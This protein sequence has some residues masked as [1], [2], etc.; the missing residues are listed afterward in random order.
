MIYTLAAVINANIPKVEANAATLGDALSWI[1]GAIGVLAVIF[2]IVG[3]LRYAASGGEAAAVKQAKNTITYAILG[4]VFV[5]LAYAITQFVVKSVDGSSWENLRDSVVNTLI[6]AVG[7]I[8]TIMIVVSGIRYMTSAGDAAKITGA[9]N[10]I[11]Y[12]VIGL[13]IAILAYA[14]VNFVIGSF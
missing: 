11:F 2:I 10:G 14:I 4:L 7:I 1:Y 6:Y 3:G 8:S 9:K 12:A 13:V 5:V